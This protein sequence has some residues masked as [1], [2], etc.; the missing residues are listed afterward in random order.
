MSQERE[1]PARNP[2]LPS[3]SV[4][5]LSLATVLCFAVLGLAAAHADAAA[6]HAYVCRVP[7]GPNAGKP[8]SAEATSYSNNSGTTAAESC[9]TG[10]AMTAGID[11]TTTPPYG[12]GASVTYETADGLTISGFRLWRH[13]AVGPTTADGTGAPFTYGT[14]GQAETLVQPVC[15][16]PGGCT[17][18]GTPTSPLDPANLVGVSNLSGVTRVT[19]RASCG[20]VAGGTCPANGALYSAVYDVYAADMLLNDA[21]PP[22]A[23]GI[24][25]PLLAGGTLAGAQSVNF[26]ATDHGSGV[27]KGALLVDGV[28]VTE[29]VLDTVGGAC[30]QFDTAPDGLPA[31]L[32]TGPC[33]ASLDG[34]LT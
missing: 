26:L 20:G 8:A 27:Y 10:G 18:R 31:Y 13:E 23:S 14:Y 2:R 9:A 34:V 21:A 25:G 11:G 28:V 24:G 30:A 5:K 32:N 12:H 7:Y 29:T 3:M 15:S 33:R 17:E 6:Y 16:R 1:G 19:W 4:H 22:A